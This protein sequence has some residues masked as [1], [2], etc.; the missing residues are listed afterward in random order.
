MIGPIASN[1]QNLVEDTRKTAAV[2]RKSKRRWFHSENESGISSL[3][4][5][6]WR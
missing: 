4:L 1:A 2:T 6:L 5:R 3:Y